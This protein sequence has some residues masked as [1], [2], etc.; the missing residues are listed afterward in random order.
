MISRR[1]LFAAFAAAAFAHPL[2]LLAQQSAKIRRIGV[3]WDGARPA[4]LAAG[5]FGAFRQAMG[6]LGYVEGKNLVI[7]WRFADGKNERL[8]D[9]ATELV[10]ANVEVILS[11]STPTTHALQKATR[12]IPIVMTTIGDPIGRGFVKSLARPGAMV[13][14]TSTYITVP[15]PMSTRSSKVRIPLICRSSSRC[16]SIWS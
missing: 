6:E 1:R 5:L 16:D 15:Q 8:P 3:L 11:A 13:R 4:D 2:A 14:I 10:H 7:E 9:L 12:T